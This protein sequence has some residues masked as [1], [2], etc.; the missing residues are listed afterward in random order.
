M[1]F[2]V[3]H[4]AVSSVL[5]SSV[6]VSSSTSQSPT[7]TKITAPNIPLVKVG[8]E[9]DLDT[10]I[11]VTTSDGATT[12]KDYTV[13]CSNT[14]VTLTGHVFKSTAPG[15]ME[16]VV[17]AGG[18]SIKPTVEVK[19][20][21]GIELIDFFKTLDATPQNY[22]LTC[23]TETLNEGQYGD[24]LASTDP[25]YQAWLTVHTEK[26]NVLAGL[27]AG[28]LNR[29]EAIPLVAR[30]TSSL[31]GFKV[32][33]ATKTYVSLIGYGGIRF[34]YAGK[35]VEYGTATDIFYDPRHPYTWALLGSVPDLK[36]KEKLNAIPGTPPNMLLPPKGDAF[37]L[38]NKDALKV[39]SLY[40][41]PFF[42]V[43]PTHYAATWNLHAEREQ[44]LEQS[45]DDHLV[46]RHDPKVHNRRQH[47]LQLFLKSPFDHRR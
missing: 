35:I 15:S 45:E 39:D 7:V 16:L 44:S 2:L 27:E 20:E 14:A 47:C 5:D 34:M 17:K 6:T 36:T 32:E 28:I 25:D 31:L 21:T 38:R 37:A 9:L 13:T 3:A 23:M 26:L 12:S 4:D 22:T 46:E 43:S 30:G 11:I 8:A 29:F 18:K 10:V 1:G 40:Q 41:P 33:N 24:E 42:E 19:T